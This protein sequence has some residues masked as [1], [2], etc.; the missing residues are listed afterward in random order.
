M[1]EVTAGYSCL[2][3]AKSHEI[4]FFRLF[5]SPYVGFGDGQLEHTA[6]SPLPFVNEHTSYGTCAS[7]HT[8]WQQWSYGVGQPAVLSSRPVH[9]DVGNGKLGGAVVLM[10]LLLSVVLG[11]VVVLAVVFVVVLTVAVVLG[12]EVVVVAG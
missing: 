1:P 8:Y 7:S 2:R 10:V 5:L 12:F 4:F 11:G 6:N 9:V 3:M